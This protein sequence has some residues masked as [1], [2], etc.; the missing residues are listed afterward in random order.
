M[1]YTTELTFADTSN[2]KAELKYAK[3]LA[4]ILFT[5]IFNDEISSKRVSFTL[6]APEGMFL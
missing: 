2:K 5:N 4:D 3:Y 1:F 6:E